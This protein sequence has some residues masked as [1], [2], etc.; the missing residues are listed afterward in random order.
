[1]KDRDADLREEI[2]THLAMATA[3][4]VARGETPHAAA[5]AARRELGN[6]LHVRESALDVWRRRWLEESIQDVRHALRGF[7]RSPGFA[8]VTIP[9]SY[10]HLTLPTNREV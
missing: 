3:D 5:A 2:Q 8:V 9:V 10:T 6:A 7:R 4:R 1:M